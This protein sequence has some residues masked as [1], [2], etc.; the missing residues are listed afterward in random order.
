VSQQK[1]LLSQQGSQVILGNVIVLPFNND[2]FLYVR[3]FY[4][5]ASSGSGTSFP[6]LRYVIVGT[7]NA[8]AEGTSFVSALQTLLSTTQTIPGLAPAPSPGASP[9]PSP[10]GSASPSPSA[11]PAPSPGE[12]SQQLS[13]LLSKLIADNQAAQSALHSGDYTAYGKAEAAVQSDLTQLQQ[14]LGQSGGASPSP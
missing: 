6:Q 5:L 7:Q 11:S 8:V 3:P 2:S 14:L 10:S 12:L 1:T 4:V 13:S 9:S